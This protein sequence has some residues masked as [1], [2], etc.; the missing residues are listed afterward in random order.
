MQARS[1]PRAFGRTEE[2]QG[3]QVL[4][5][6]DEAV[7]LMRRNE[8][9][10]PRCHISGPR[11]RPERRAPADDDVDLVLAVRALGIG[12]P[13]RQRVRPEAEVGGPQLFGVRWRAVDRRDISR[14]RDDLHDQHGTDRRRILP[15]PTRE[16]TLRASGTCL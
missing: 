3:R 5:D 10:T 16:R 11:G 12:A 8:D 7:W 15:S 4:C 13:R 1:G 6:V 9:R 2:D 14:S